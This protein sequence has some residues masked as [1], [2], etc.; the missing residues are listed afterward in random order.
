[1]LLTKRNKMYF[2]ECPSCK[3]KLNS[4]LMSVYEC[5]L[6]YECKCCHYKTQDALFAELFNFKKIQHYRYF[7][8][9]FHDEFKIKHLGKEVTV[10]FKSRVRDKFT[11]EYLGEDVVVKTSKLG[12]LITELP[13]PI[14][15]DNLKV[16]AL[17]RH[18]YDDG[19]KTGFKTIVDIVPF[20]IV[21]KN[22]EEE[23]YFIGWYMLE[24]YLENRENRK[25]YDKILQSYKTVI[26]N[27]KENETFIK[28]YD[29]QYLVTSVPDIGERITT[30]TIV[31]IVNFEGRVN[32]IKSPSWKYFHII[33][34]KDVK[35][36]WDTIICKQCGLGKSIKKNEISLVKRV[37]KDCDKCCICNSMEDLQINEIYITQENEK[38]YVWNAFVCKDCGDVIR[39]RLGK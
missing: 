12:D 21:Y 1:L 13:K 32:F 4:N 31:E 8:E 20:G 27:F 2:I 23:C 22:E 26:E 7:D 3:T 6:S 29:E 34:N 19:T 5:T 10:K 28:L 24:K 17:F 33:N 11:Y 35:E 36:D 38:D 30:S 14:N 9:Y 39:G 25:K 15:V 18:F 37:C 16:G